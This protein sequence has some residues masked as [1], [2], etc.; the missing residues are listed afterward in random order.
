MSNGIFNIPRLIYNSIIEELRKYVNNK[1]ELIIIS[2][3]FFANFNMHLPYSQCNI[4]KP[5]RLKCTPP[6]PTRA[7][8]LPNDVFH[9][10]I[11]CALRMCPCLILSCLTT[12]AW[13]LMCALSESHHACAHK[14]RPKIYVNHRQA[15]NFTSQVHRGEH[16]RIIFHFASHTAKGTYL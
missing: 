4:N 15:L 6:L 7:M 14:L 12:C 1:E 2:I 5:H 9:V 13:L 16:Q 11:S 8:K 3:F 10:W